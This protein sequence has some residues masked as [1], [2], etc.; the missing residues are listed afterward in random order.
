MKFCLRWY[1]QY[2]SADVF[3][4]CSSMS[5]PLTTATLTSPTFT[6]FLELWL[7]GLPGDSKLG[8]EIARCCKPVFSTAILDKTYWLFLSQFWKTFWG[9]GNIVLHNYGCRGEV[10]IVFNSKHNRNRQQMTIHVHVYVSFEA[11]YTCTC[12]HFHL[13]QKMGSLDMHILVCLTCK[14]QN[15]FCSWTTWVHN[16]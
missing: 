14:A 4:T 8:T 11:G 15:K 2:F 10:K 6:H 7:A 1:Q 3:P 16:R 13:Y 9:M 5:C 12:I